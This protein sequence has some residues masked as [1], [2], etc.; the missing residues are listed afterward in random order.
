MS[1][2]SGLFYLIKM[3][4]PNGSRQALL[5]LLFIIWLLSNVVNVALAKDMSSRLAFTE[6]TG[7]YWTA[8]EVC[9]RNGFA[10]VDYF[11]LKEFFKNFQ[12]YSLS[13]PTDIQLKE[14]NRKVLQQSGRMVEGIF[15]Q[16]SPNNSSKMF[17]WYTQLPIMKTLEF[18]DQSYP[19]HLIV[20]EK[21]SLGGDGKKALK[22]WSYCVE[23]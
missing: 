12:I 21:E 22:F 6:V 17:S 9:Q 23:K 7:F 11:L 8:G 3:R 13:L 19:A 10:H 16:A 1:T 4:L 5:Y 18:G 15:W 14:I 2:Y 20:I